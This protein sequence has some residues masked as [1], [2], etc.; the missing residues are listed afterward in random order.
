MIFLFFAV[1]MSFSLVDSMVS[2]GRG[3][4]SWRVVVVLDA[5]IG[6]ENSLC[7]V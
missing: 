7:S 2:C 3:L 5:I 4:S 1:K 6:D